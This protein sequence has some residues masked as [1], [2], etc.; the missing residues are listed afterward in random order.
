MSRPPLVLAEGEWYSEYQEGPGEPLHLL[1]WR[2]SVPVQEEI[3]CFNMEANHV[4]KFSHVVNYFANDRKQLER[5]ENSYSSGHVKNMQFDADMIPAHLQGDVQASMK[6]RV[7]KVEV[8][9]K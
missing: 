4:I 2:R 5:G 8:E 6:K 1:F 7:Y 9:I 3:I